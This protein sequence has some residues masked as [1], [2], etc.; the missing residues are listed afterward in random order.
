MLCFAKH[1]EYIKPSITL[2]I[3]CDGNT[4]WLRRSP[5]ELVET[6]TSAH[7]I[8]V[9][10]NTGR[11]VE[12]GG[13]GMASTSNS[14]YVK[15]TYF[16]DT[17]SPRTVTA[18]R[19]LDGNKMYVDWCVNHMNRSTIAFQWNNYIPEWAGD[20]FNKAK[21]RNIARSRLMQKRYFVELKTEERKLEQMIE[22]LL[23]NTANHVQ[24]II[25][26]AITERRRILGERTTFNVAGAL[27]GRISST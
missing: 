16:K 8:D 4:V 19:M 15:F 27:T 25:R 18:A 5:S 13:V 6:I 21:A 17:E 11:L 3:E 22:W 7:A 9:W 14:Q 12:I 20:A 10:V 2:S 26:N 23:A 24:H 1:N